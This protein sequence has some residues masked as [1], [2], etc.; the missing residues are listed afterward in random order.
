M[1]ASYVYLKYIEN[2]VCTILSV[3]TMT[4]TFTRNKFGGIQLG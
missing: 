4:K 2:D 3:S 1:S